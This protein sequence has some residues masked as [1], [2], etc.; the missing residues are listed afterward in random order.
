MGGRNVHDGALRVLQSL[1]QRAR[2]TEQEEPYVRSDLIVA[3]AAGMQL[4]GHRADK[5]PEAPLDGRVDVLICGGKRE[6]PRAELLSDAL[7]PRHE[8]RDLIR[9]Q[10]AGALER[11]RVGR[12]RANIIL[13]QAP[14]HLDRGVEAPHQCV[15]LTG[16]APA[17]QFAHLQS[18]LKAA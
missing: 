8:R 2:L 18:R 14:V 6:G 7:Q 5:F 4:A 11:P 9:R 10:H 16:K 17:P 13:R 12:A 1:L 3:A 15:G